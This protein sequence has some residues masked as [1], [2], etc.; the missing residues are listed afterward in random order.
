M[1]KENYLGSCQD[2]YCTA[3][4]KELHD[5]YWLPSAHDNNLAFL[6]MSELWNRVARRKPFLTRKKTTTS[7]YTRKLK[8]LWSD[9]TKSKRHVRY[10]I[11]H[12]TKEYHNHGAAWLWQHYALGLLFLKPGLCCFFF[13]FYQSRGKHE[14]QLILLQNLVSVSCAMLIKNTKWCN[15]ICITK[16]CHFYRSF[17]LLIE[18]IFFVLMKMWAN[19]CCCF[20]CWKS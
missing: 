12:I 4:L 9:E 1:V 11:K 18:F 20:K 3:T 15:K 5:K 17:T 10:K 14:Y 6:H 19:D 13:F 7:L 2:T 8:V 16:S